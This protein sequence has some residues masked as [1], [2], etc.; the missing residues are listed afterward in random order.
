VSNYEEFVSAYHEHFTRDP[1]ACVNLGVEKHLG[2]LPDPSHEAAA[3]EVEE[4]REL[5]HRAQALLSGDLPF[6]TRLDLDLAILSLESEIHGE[7]YLFNGRTARAQKPTAG[8]DIGDGIFMLFINDPRP[9]HSRL[10]DITS[11]IQQIP[12]YLDALLARLDTPVAR[13]VKMDL[14]KVGGLDSLFE[15]IQNWAEEE[16]WTDVGRLRQGRRDAHVAIADYAQ[17]LKAMP[18]TK[19]LHVGKEIAQEIV[20]TRGVSLS[21]EELHGIARDFLGKTN[22]QLEALAERLI[23][24]YEMPA[25]SSL[26]EVHSF[27]NKRF[28]VE[29]PPG[30]LEALLARYQEERSRILAF[31]KERDLF[32]IF[33]GQDMLILR[34]PKFMEPS[35]PAGAMMSP[36]PFREGIRKSIVYLTL[37]EAL[38]DE[39]TELT[40]PTMMVH[41]GIPGHH[42]QLATAGLHD[43][44]IRRHCDCMDLCEGWTTMLEEY[45]LDMGYC[46]D[47]ADEVR[48]CGRRDISRI[49]A[50]VAIDLFF[51]TGD[52]KY[53]D[54]GVDCDLSSDDPFEAAGNLLAAV[55]GFVPSRVQAELNWYSQER[56]YPLSYLTGNHLVWELKRDVI[57]AQSGQLEGMELDRLFHRTFLEAGNMPVSFLRRVFQEKEILPAAA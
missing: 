7:T 18:T 30:D 24:R 15:T 41:E 9:A 35:I 37:S 26:A 4:A 50:R 49:G 52:K 43:S 46:A 12:D 31:I 23:P 32:P 3:L 19:Q 53:L 36:P 44:L 33:D 8:N 2:D 29:V 47:L 40:I 1:N 11:R 6:D 13:W 21:F 28:R 17:A 39:H 42:L 34:T 25:E 27:L 5:L 38:M 51:M 14:E 54:V 57:S 20:R 45:M 48:F 56:G 55:T 10:A 16:S 22:Q